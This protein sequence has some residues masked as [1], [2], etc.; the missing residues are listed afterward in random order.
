MELR[1]TSTFKDIDIDKMLET[2]SFDEFMH[3]LYI[4]KI[5]EKEPSEKDNLTDFEKM[6]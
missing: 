4:N 6:F 2:T 1:S 5:Q 3:G